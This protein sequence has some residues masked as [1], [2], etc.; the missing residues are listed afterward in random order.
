MSRR[1]AVKTS[2]IA[3]KDTTP[4]SVYTPYVK[5]LLFAG[6]NM[7]KTYLPLN[8]YF[9]T[10]K[11]KKVLFINTDQPENFLKNFK[12]L[13]EN[14][15]NRVIQPHEGDTIGHRMN[16]LQAIEPLI[17]QILTPPI[18][19]DIQEGKIGLIVV[20]SLDVITEA[21]E[22]YAVAN[23]FSGT[24]EM[25]VRGRGRAQME[26]EFLVPLINLPVNFIATSSY[27]LL[28]I[29]KKKG[30]K[31][32]L[33]EIAK[34][35]IGE[36]IIE[37]HRPR[38]HPRY[39]KHF[40][41]IMELRDLNPFDKSKSQINGYFIKSKREQGQFSYNVLKGD[42]KTKKGPSYAK[43]IAYDRGL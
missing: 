41:N 40:T 6:T 36:E 15:Q 43:Y 29:E 42:T 3:L 20:D 16:K 22:E 18:S 23:D 31:G 19:I 32:P 17:K 9:K 37:V 26:R 27:D 13:S 14:E 7:G 12:E 10:E 30:P 25:F 21:Y 39:W 8:S 5:G 28:Y 1:R 4:S 2:N 24:L 34:V 11:E 38:A 33:K 35:E